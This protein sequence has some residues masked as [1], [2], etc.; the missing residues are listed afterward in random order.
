[1]HGQVSSTQAEQDEKKNP[2]RRKVFL[3]KMEQVV[4]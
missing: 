1:M 3:E 4:P 2:A